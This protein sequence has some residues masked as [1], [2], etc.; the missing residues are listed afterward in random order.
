MTGDLWAVAD[1]DA[2]AW[3]V[4]PTNGALKANGTL[5]MGAGV[6]GAAQKRHPGLAAA[7]GAHVKAAGNV[8][9]ALPQFRV[10]SW[11]TKPAEHTVDDKTHP[12]WMCAARV[13]H[14]DCT[15]QVATLTWAGAHQVVRLVAELNLTGPILLPHVGCGLGGLD[16]AKVGPA[17]AGVLDDRFIAI[18]PA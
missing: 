18:A 2:S 7:L 15:R 11:P 4:I 5:V 16:W 17:L 12:G 3:V 6:A 1:A 9:A 14:D 10:L 8:A 13:R